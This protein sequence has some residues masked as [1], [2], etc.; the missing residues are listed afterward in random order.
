MDI[1]NNIKLLM[2]FMIIKDAQT[3]QVSTHNN[4]TTTTTLTLA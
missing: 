4:K 2:E 1:D 3:G